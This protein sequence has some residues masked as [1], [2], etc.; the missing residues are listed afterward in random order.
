M[1]MDDDGMM[2][3]FCEMRQIDH[4][5]CV[6]HDAIIN[7]LQSVIYVASRIFSHTFLDVD[8]DS[9]FLSHIERLFLSVH[10]ILIQLWAQ[11]LILINLFVH[12][13]EIQ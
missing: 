11:R 7:S 5:I 13:S 6:F 3:S 12:F 9:T 2:G 10:S 4:S 1:T 8:L